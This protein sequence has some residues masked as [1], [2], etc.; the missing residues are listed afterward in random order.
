MSRQRSK[1]ENQNRHPRG[2]RRLWHRPTGATAALGC[3]VCPERTI[4]G[5]LSVERAL[6]DCLQFCCER[7]DGCDRVCRKHPDY[8]DRVREVSTFSLDTVPRAPVLSAPVLPSLVPVIYHG[9]RRVK[10]PAMGAVALSLYALFDR[11]SGLPRYESRSSIDEA[12][13]LPPDA[14]VILTGTDRDRP[15]ERWWALR[16]EGRRRIIEAMIAA[17][18]GLVTTPNFSLFTDRPR[19]DDLHAMARIAIV[20]EEFLRAGLPAALHVNGRTD[21]DFGRWADYIA[22]RSEITHVAYEFA[23]G[24]GWKT[25]RG[26][27]AAWL[28]G[29]AA[30]VNRPLHLLMRGGMDQLPTLVKG[31]SG[32]TILNTSI[33]MKTMKRQ[34]AYP[35]RSSAV[36]WKSVPTDRG[37]PVDSLLAT[38]FKTVE[39]WAR[40]LFADA[41]DGLGNAG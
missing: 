5:G 1:D 7:P 8:V 32:L 30:A 21:A 28:A 23:T 37:A 24:T 25:R 38:N 12:F 9:T 41:N 29:M 3:T 33:F 19:W 34:C 39:A 27:H 13:G 35:E 31:F 10:A 6:F 40:D 26:Q 20:H 16:E 14:T 17:G 22:A 4:C 11:R 36:R 18:I 15:L 2:E